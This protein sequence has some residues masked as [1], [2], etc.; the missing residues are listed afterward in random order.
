M[1]HTGTHSLG[2]ELAAAF[3]PNRVVSR[4]AL[5]ILIAADR[6]IFPVAGRSILPAIS[7]R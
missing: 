3:L 7:R 5:Q 1:N 6:S 4:T 2:A